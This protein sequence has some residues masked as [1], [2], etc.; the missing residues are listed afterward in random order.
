MQNKKCLFPWR[1][2]KPPGNF[3]PNK[4]GVSDI[5]AKVGMAEMQQVESII[6]TEDGSI[7]KCDH[8]KGLQQIGFYC[9]KCNSYFKKVK[10]AKNHPHKV[11]GIIL[12]LFCNM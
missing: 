9:F 10:Q 8:V 4:L 2:S 12:H 7:P 1:S 5:E 11:W 3:N 6:K